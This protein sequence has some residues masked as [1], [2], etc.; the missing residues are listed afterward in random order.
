MP[1]DFSIKC[2]A[3]P[4]DRDGPLIPRLTQAGWFMSLHINEVRGCPKGLNID[5]LLIFDMQDDGGLDGIEIIQRID[6]DIATGYVFPRWDEEEY[7]RLFLEPSH[8]DVGEP[9]VTVTMAW[10]DYVLTYRWSNRTVDKTY[11]LGPGVT[12]F[13]GAGQLLGFQTDITSLAK[14]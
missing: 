7:W 8:H 4:I 13:V 5:S 3:A 9:E 2:R 12:A 10:V 1:S 11:L 6:P 14:R